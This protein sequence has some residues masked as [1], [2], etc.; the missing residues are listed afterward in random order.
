MNLYRVDKVFLLNLL[1]KGKSTYIILPPPPPKK[2][3]KKKTKNKQTNKQNV[4]HLGNAN[5][6]V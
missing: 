6:V 2:K 4:Y 1:S 3:T 5:A